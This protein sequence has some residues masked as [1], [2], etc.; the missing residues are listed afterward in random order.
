MRR[1]DEA[2][3]EPVGDLGAEISAHHMQ[4]EIDA[5]SAAGGGQQPALIHIENVRLDLDIGISLRK[6]LHIM[7]VGRRAPARQK[8]RGRKHEDAG[9]DGHQ[10]RAA[11]MGV[12]QGFDEGWRDRLGGGSAPAG[13]HDGVRLLQK[14]EPAIGHDLEAADGA[15]WAGLDG[16]DGEAVPVRLPSPACGRPKISTAMPNSKV[17]RRS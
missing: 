14:F 7:P 8:A 16:A 13:N 5:R 2:A 9:A 10:P 15:Q 17:L 6:L 3:G 12:P 4:A 11:L 1:D